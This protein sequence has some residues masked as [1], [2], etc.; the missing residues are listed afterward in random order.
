MAGWN[1]LF[2]MGLL[3]ISLWSIRRA[4]RNH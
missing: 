4:R 2:S 1:L 3:G